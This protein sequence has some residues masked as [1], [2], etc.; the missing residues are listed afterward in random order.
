MRRDRP[1]AYADS[2]PLLQIILC[3]PSSREIPL[4]GRHA[5]A[6]L[7]NRTAAKQNHSRR[8][9]G[10]FWPI[11]TARAFD[12]VHLKIQDSRSANLSSAYELELRSATDK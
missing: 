10:N 6:Y 2:I 8:V 5:E 9:T 12:P 3:S 7:N 1:T 11:P 4:G